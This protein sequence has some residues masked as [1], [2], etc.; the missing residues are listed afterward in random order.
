GIS[1]IEMDIKIDGLTGE[2]IEEGVEEGGEGGLGI[3]DDM[4]ERIEE[5]GEELS[6]Y[7]RKVVSMSINGDKIGEVIGGGGKKMNEIMEESGVKLDIEQDGR[8]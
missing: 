6:G 3:M 4:V 1:A 8:M 7:G 5:R 2:V